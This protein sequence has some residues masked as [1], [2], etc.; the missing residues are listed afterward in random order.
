METVSWYP[1]TRAEVEAIHWVLAVAR[2]G[3]YRAGFMLSAREVADLERRLVFPSQMSPIIPKPDTETAR[4]GLR[5]R[6]WRST[7]RGFWGRV[8]AVL[9]G[10]AQ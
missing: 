2:S 8:R 4:P 6:N 5:M 9:D 1:L 3:Y 7:L 10:G